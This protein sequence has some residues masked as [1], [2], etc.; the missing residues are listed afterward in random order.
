MAVTSNPSLCGKQEDTHGYQ[1][2]LALNWFVMKQTYFH[3][4][5]F[6]LIELI[7]INS[8]ELIGVVLG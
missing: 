4:I 1:H 6:F 8:F 3:Q 5:D 2:E 7:W